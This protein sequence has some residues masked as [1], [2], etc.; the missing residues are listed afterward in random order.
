[1]PLAVVERVTTTE[2]DPGNYINPDTAASTNQEHLDD[3]IGGGDRDDG[4]DR[5][6]LS[7]RGVVS[8][9]NKIVN[10]LGLR[11]STTIKHE[12]PLQ[13]MTKAR[14]EQDQPLQ[15]ELNKEGGALL[16]LRT[17]G[18]LEERTWLGS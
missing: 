1:M 5:K 6:M 11:A 8:D 3:C 10:P 14:P 12:S 15:D 18:L 13:R 2:D 7:R 16:H 9:V 17:S 4:A